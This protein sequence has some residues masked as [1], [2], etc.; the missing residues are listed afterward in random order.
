[1]GDPKTNEIIK[2]IAGRYLGKTSVIFK[3]RCATL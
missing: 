1:M 2:M 3:R